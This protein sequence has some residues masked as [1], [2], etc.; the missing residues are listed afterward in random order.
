MK[1]YPTA[2]GYMGFI[3]GKWKLYATED[4]YREEYE[5]EKRSN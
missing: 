4:E 3:N 2:F 1:G 5:N